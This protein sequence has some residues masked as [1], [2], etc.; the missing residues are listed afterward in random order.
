[1]TLL[2][3]FAQRTRAALRWRQNN[4]A[5]RVRLSAR[6]LR[7]WKS[8]L[9]CVCC[10]APPAMSVFP[11]K[12]QPFMTGAREFLPILMRPRRPWQHAE[13]NRA[14]GCG[15]MSRFR[16]AGCIFCWSCTVSWQCGLSWQLM[17]VSMTGLS[18]GAWRAFLNRRSCGT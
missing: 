1:M 15:L 3:S 10:I 5:C 12:A 6:E 8:G 11:M 17:S 13:R 4:S 7:G 18:G 2:L 9:V 14:G 16:S